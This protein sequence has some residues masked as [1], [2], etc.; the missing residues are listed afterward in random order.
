MNKCSASYNN[1]IDPYAQLC[2]FDVAKSINVK[3]FNL[4]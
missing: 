1:V 4:R 2:A 3:F